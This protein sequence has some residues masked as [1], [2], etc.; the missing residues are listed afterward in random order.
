MI[1]LNCV[2]EEVSSKDFTRLTRRNA[3]RATRREESVNVNC[4]TKEYMWG[5]INGNRSN[6]ALRQTTKTNYKRSTSASPHKCW[7]SSNNFCPSVCLRSVFRRSVQFF[8]FSAPHS[9]RRTTVPSLRRCCGSS[10]NAGTSQHPVVQL[11]YD[12]TSSRHDVYCVQY[13][14]RVLVYIHLF[15][16]SIMA[17]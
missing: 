10:W 9:E 7:S 11:L 6:C 1:V 8:M 17:K 13:Y 16:L 14:S 4:E 15:V 5:E 12:V 3:L 2:T